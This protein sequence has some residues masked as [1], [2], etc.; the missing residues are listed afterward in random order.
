VLE[1]PC[2]VGK[3]VQ[4]GVRKRGRDACLSAKERKKLFSRFSRARHA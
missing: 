2:Q 4:V 3:F 1:K